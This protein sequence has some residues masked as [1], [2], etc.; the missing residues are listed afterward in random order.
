MD[1]EKYVRMLNLRF[2]QTPLLA[3]ISRQDLELIIVKS[4]VQKYDKDEII[5]QEDDFPD[6]FL[7]ILSGS[8]EISR[9]SAEGIKTVFRRLYPP[10]SI[11]Y[12]LLAGKAHSADIIASEPS[13]LAL[14]PTSTIKHIFNQNPELNFKAIDRLSTLVNTLSTE[15]IEIKTMSLEERVL[16]TIK[17]N[18]NNRDELEISHDDLAHIVGASRA[19]VSRALK[20]LESKKSIQLDRIKISIL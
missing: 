10:S 3:D 7:I 18:A 14:I 4:I 2:S 9:H 17:R 5:V 19:N 20:K 11:G 8:V 13:M 1:N 16:C 15:L 6:F 12:C